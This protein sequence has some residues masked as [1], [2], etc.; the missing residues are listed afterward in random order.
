[1]LGHSRNVRQQHGMVATSDFEIIVL[2]ARTTAQ[3]FEIEPDD[4]M[5]T[6]NRLY[7][8]SKHFDVATSL[9]PVSYTHLDVYK[10]QPR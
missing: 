2:R 7:I 9:A 6:A 3:G 5:T 8:S 1:M 10:R 4:A